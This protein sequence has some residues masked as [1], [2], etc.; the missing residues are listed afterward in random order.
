MWCH[1]RILKIPWIQQFTN[2]EVVKKL[3]NGYEVIKT[4]EMRNLKCLG[5]IIGEEKYK[6]L[7]LI[8]QGKIKGKRNIGRRRISGLR[9][10]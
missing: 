9:V 3:Q 5:H 4:V 8:M 6:I 2:A 7:R 1:R 10:V